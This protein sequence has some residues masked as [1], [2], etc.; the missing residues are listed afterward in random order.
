MMPSP[1][2]IAV[3]DDNPQFR[4]CVIHVLKRVDGFEIVGE[5]ASATDALGVVQK[6]GPD[7]ILLDLRLPGGGTKAAARIARHYPSV[8]TVVLTASECEHDVASALQAGARGY[9][10]KGGSESHLI[11]A[12]Y[13][14]VR[15]NFYFT[16]NFAERLLIERSKRV[17]DRPRQSLATS[18]FTT[19]DSLSLCRDECLN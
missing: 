6:C 7:I 10:L 9:V 15:G 11:D 19:R 16:P 18:L 2:R 4:D 5:G 8:R 3:F 14:V 17:E 1:I 13:A 12:V